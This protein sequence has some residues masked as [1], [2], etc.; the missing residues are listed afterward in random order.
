MTFLSRQSILCVL[1][2]LTGFFF[3]HAS[4]WSTTLG[5]HHHRQL[6]TG[7]N[8]RG[9]SDPS[10]YSFSLPYANSNEDT[11]P[12][13]Q[14]V[15]IQGVTISPNGFQVLLQT[16]SGHFPILV[17]NDPQDAFAAT[18]P[19]ALTLIQLLSGVDMAGAIL[20]PDVLARILVQHAEAT[21]LCCPK[22]VDLVQASLPDNVESY[23]TASPWMQNKI[24]LPT[25][26]LDQLSL[27]VTPD[28]LQFRLE[29]RVLSSEFQ[30]TLTVRP[31]Q[32]SIEH[33]CYQYEQATSEAFVCL[34]LALR[35]K[36]P[37]VLQQ[38]GSSTRT[39]EFLDPKKL[40]Q[41]FPQ[42]TTVS[43]LQQQS[44]RV[45]RSIERGFEYHKWTGALTIA[46]ERGDT[47]AA[48]GIQ[49]KLDEMDSLKDLPTLSVD[50]QQ[51]IGDQQGTNDNIMQ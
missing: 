26:T 43:N 33:V 9:S 49:A 36:A 12:T 23:T 47:K 39:T 45:I 22:L 11:P 3:R 10:R 24:S 17:T 6:A 1:L 37:I 25:V 48:A 16:K 20:P 2:S 19:E 7:R 34:A 15:S 32:D 38:G 30:Q 50:T 4:A 18:S 35:Y 27:I 29:C 51:I 5:H 41:V 28:G 8:S 14:R 31:S 40:Q 46:L 44:T 13:L 21:P 42:M